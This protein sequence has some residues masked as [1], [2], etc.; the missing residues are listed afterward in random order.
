MHTIDLLL[1]DPLGGDLIY[2]HYIIYPPL[3][4]KIMHITKYVISKHVFLL[5]SETAKTVRKKTSEEM[6]H[7]DANGE[8][9]YEEV[10]MYEYTRRLGHML[11]RDLVDA[12]RS[13]RT[14]FG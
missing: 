3:E 1:T 7:K 2:R 12:E 10:N 4:D 9:I 11:G 14:D 13:I 8:I 5:A 6:I